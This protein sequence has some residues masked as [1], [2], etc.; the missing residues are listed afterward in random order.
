[1]RYFLIMFV[2]LLLWP[3]YLFADSSDK[4]LTAFQMTKEN[5]APSFYTKVQKLK[6]SQ[7]YELDM[8]LEKNILVSRAKTIEV[9]ITSSKGLDPDILRICFLTNEKSDYC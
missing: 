7:L 2:N 8:E 6:N 9:G 1:M 4:H 5:P 3:H